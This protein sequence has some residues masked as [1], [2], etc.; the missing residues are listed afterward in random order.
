[1]TAYV[2]LVGVHLLCHYDCIFATV[3]SVVAVFLY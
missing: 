1:M 3:I 2:L